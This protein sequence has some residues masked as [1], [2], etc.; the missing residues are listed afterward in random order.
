MDD[1]EFAPIENAS[2]VSILFYLWLNPL[3]RLGYSRALEA[4]DVHPAP[5]LLRSR[6]V[7]NVIGKAWEEEKTLALKE[8]RQPYLGYAIRRTFWLGFVLAALN[9]CPYIVVT[10]VQPFFL[11]AL[12]T[13]VTTKNVNFV[14]IINNGYSIAC[15]LGGISVVSA[16]CFNFTFYILSK[17]GMRC[18]STVMIMVYTKAFKLSSPSKG[19]HTTGEIITL[20]SVDAERVWSAAQF[21][22]R[23]WNPSSPEKYRVIEESD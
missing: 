14:G 15:L 21:I 16:I 8:N 5:S 19:K 7:H 6:A 11:S 18:R 10:L 3:L 20:M 17:E 2:I 9:T 23:F 12:L 4:G 22:L 1:D 13:Y